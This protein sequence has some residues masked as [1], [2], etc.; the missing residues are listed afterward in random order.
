MEF[1]LI[2]IDLDGTLLSSTKEISNRNKQA[3]LDC[4]E[5]G[6]KFIFA[7][8]RPPRA[9]KLFMKEELLKIGSFIYY[10]GAYMECRH[11][12]IIKHLPIEAEVTAEILDYCLAYNP[13]L[14][15]S[16]EVKDE[17]LSLR[18]YDAETLMRVKGKPVVKS[19]EELGGL[20]ASKIL[21]SGDVDMVSFQERFNR[22][23]N[24]LVTDQAKLVQISSLQASKERAAA[25]LGEAMN[26][27]LGNTMVFG[28]DWN[29]IGLFETCGWPVAM[30]NAID[31]LKLRSKEITATN[32]HDGVAEVLER[33][34][35]LSRS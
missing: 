16:L 29:D 25:V 20:E 6:M 17:W 8:A 33:L 10:N 7:T 3:I 1:P 9:V 5:R 11:T 2:I 18:E 13:D 28:D 15:L 34:C 24:I 23:V 30:G 19:R 4:A 12:G 26:I 32:D 31:E 14:D 35:R 27:S 21:F 22:K